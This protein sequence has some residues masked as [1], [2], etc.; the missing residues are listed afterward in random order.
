[1]GIPRAEYQTILFFVDNVSTKLQSNF[2]R[3]AFLSQASVSILL[4]S[5]FLNN[6]HISLLYSILSQ[7][8]YLGE[9]FFLLGSFW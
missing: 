1:V 5:L 3:V 7:D 9:E 6:I 4:Y 2:P 8:K